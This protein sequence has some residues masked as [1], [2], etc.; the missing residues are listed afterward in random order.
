MKSE[1]KC[2]KCDTEIVVIENK[3]FFSD[4]ISDLTIDCPI[5]NSEIL[6]T[7]TDG[8]FFIQTKKEYLIDL[9][10]EENKIRLASPIA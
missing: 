4:E 1:T 5:C 3:L 6:K 8:W 7:N 10:I 2:P 9:E